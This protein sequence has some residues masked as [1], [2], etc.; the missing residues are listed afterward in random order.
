[1]NQLQKDK[2]GTNW[3]DLQCCNAKNGLSVR[4]KRHVLPYNCFKDAFRL[5]SGFVEYIL[6]Y[7]GLIMAALNKGHALL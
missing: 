3:S 7:S 5:V 4:G 6:R 2:R 1:M